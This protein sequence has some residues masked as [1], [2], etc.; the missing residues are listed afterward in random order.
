[1]LPSYTSEASRRAE[2][3]PF[4]MLFFVVVCSLL[5]QML[6]ICRLFSILN[7]EKHWLAAA[8]GVYFLGGRHDLEFLTHST[9]KNSFLIMSAKSRSG[10]EPLAQSI[11]RSRL[12]LL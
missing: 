1:L 2:N 6:F 3:R 12:V 11:G 4:W 8:A 9:V 5:A 10:L 7:T